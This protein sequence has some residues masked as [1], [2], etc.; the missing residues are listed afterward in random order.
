[1]AQTFLVLTL[2]VGVGNA[3][4]ATFPEVKAQNLEH[5][6]LSLPGDFSGDL[7]LVLITY[8]SDQQREADSWLEAA[9]ELFKGYPGIPVYEVPTLGKEYKWF[10]FIIDRSMRY[11]MTKQEQ[12]A[13][14]FTLYI[15]KAPFEKALQ[16]EN[17][18]RIAVLL[19]DKKGRVL[20]REEGLYY[21]IKGNSLRAALAKLRSK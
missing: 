13:H 20:W 11:G 8:E 16:I 10:K 2:L 12:R 6:M 5:Q 4:Q 21:D 17:E 3:Q 9:P 14:T 1:V 19:V 18:K 7:N 15:D